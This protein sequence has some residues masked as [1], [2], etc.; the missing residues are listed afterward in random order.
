MKY[1]VDSEK[2]KSIMLNQGLSINT[3]ACNSGL[4]T[5]T[6]SR[7]L[8]QGRSV[9]AQTIKKIADALSILPEDLIIKK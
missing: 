4:S 7:A 6:I 1:S 9:S 2:L 5:G 3:L 8:K